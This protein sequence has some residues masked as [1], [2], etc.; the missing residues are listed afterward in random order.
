MRK[1][2]TV[3]TLATKP[4]GSSESTYL[5]PEDQRENTANNGEREI[6][7]EGDKERI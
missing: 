6:E 4:Y 5:P 2:Q 3:H 1:F 7:R